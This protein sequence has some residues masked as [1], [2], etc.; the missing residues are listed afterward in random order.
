MLT[1]I[2]L[3]IEASKSSNTHKGSHAPFG[4]NNPTLCELT[5]HRTGE[6]SRSILCP[7]IITKRESTRHREAS[8]SFRT[9]QIVRQGPLNPILRANPFPK[10]TD[11]FCRLPLPTLL[12]A[13]E[14][15]NLGDL[16]RL[17][18]RSEVQIKLSFG[19]SRAVGNASDPSN[20]KV[21]YQPINPIAR[22]SDFKEKGLL[23]RKDNASRSSHLHCRIP[24]RYRTLSTSWLD[25]IDPI[26]F[27]DTRQS[28]RVRN[29]PVF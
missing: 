4:V 20:D 15:A 12:C 23:N 21:L 8:S 17:W 6:S 25:N 22:Q 1:G 26:P 11:L 19:F 5:V 28:L 13:P 9:A 29:T 10:V 27:Q 18:V 3:G 16:M 7:S 24:V 14:A 2:V